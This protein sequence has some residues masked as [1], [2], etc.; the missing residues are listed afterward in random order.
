MQH[1]PHGP[2]KRRFKTTASNS[3]C[4]GLRDTFRGGGGINSLLVLKPEL[5][6]KILEFQ[7]GCLGVN[8]LRPY[9]WTVVQY[10]YCTCT[11][12]VKF[13]IGSV[14][15]LDPEQCWSKSVKNQQIGLYCFCEPTQLIKKRILPNGNFC[16]QPAFTCCLISELSWIRIFIK[17]NTI[18]NAE[19][20]LEN[21][22]II[23]NKRRIKLL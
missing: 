12:T 1:T 3:A 7:T 2:P 4:H 5:G 15:I 23:T 13:N 9:Y 19:C 17:T 16:N 10:M 8:L 18:R 14:S 21:V 22:K 20:K 11:C 6:K